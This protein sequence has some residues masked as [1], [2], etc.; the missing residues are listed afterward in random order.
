MIFG[1]MRSRTDGRRRSRRSEILG[2]EIVQFC[3]ILLVEIR[4]PRGQAGVRASSVSAVV[5]PRYTPT[6]ALAIAS[7]E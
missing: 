7:H 2:R 1:R 4:F 6:D 3:T 5:A